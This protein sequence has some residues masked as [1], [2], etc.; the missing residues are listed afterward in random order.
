MPLIFSLE[1]VL[2]PGEHAALH[3]L[4]PSV[5]E[6]SLLLGLSYMR[7]IISET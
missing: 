7:L 4:E 5:C 6:M 1:A 3:A 2:C